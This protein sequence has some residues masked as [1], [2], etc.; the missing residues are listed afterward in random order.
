MLP[1]STDHQVNGFTLLETIVSLVIIGFIAI[2]IGN[3]LVYS[4]KLFQTSKAYDTTMPQLDAAFNIIRMSIQDG[5]E[6][7]IEHNESS[8]LLTIKS[9]K[10]STENHVLLENV[11]E[12]KIIKNES[13]FS[14]S[15]ATVTHAYL[16]LD[17][18]GNE[19]NIDFVVSPNKID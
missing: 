12:Y 14:G 4:V 5:T 13:A 15:S 19:K 2:S 6:S 1:T 7:L 11:S 8:K 3:G 9:S 10:D 16:T 17:F 18:N